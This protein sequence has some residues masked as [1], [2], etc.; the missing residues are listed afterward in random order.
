MEIDLSIK[1]IGYMTGF[2]T[3]DTAGLKMFVSVENPLQSSKVILLSKCYDIVWLYLYI[4]WKSA[5]LM[6]T[7]QGIFKDFG[8]IFNQLIYWHIKL[9]R[10]F[11]NM[12][13]KN[14]SLKLLL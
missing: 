8:A 1:S 6:S 3:G 11:D 14:K 9:D 13:V 12:I 7:K 4:H 2:W 10:L 5:K